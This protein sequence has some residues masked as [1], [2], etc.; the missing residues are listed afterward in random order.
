MLSAT[1]NMNHQ[2]VGGQAVESVLGNLF[3]IF[4]LSGLGNWAIDPVMSRAGMLSVA[5]RANFAGS[6]T[7][8]VPTYIF[9]YVNL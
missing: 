6:F 7:R 3:Q 4:L 2:C 5:L 9:T 8:A 1:V